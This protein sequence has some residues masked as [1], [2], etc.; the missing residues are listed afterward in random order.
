M[1]NSGR[2]VKRVL[3][4]TIPSAMALGTGCLYDIRQSVISAG[5]DFVEGTAGTII[6]SLIPVDTLLGGE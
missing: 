5:L 4:W 3:A 2:I 1:R 6:E